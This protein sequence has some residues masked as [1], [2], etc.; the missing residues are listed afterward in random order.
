MSR[1]YQI[2]TAQVEAARK[3]EEAQRARMADKAARYAVGADEFCNGWKETREVTRET[4]ETSKTKIIYVDLRVYYEPT[5]HDIRFDGIVE[6]TTPAPKPSWRT[7]TKQW[8]SGP[9]PHEGKWPLARPSENKEYLLASGKVWPYRA[10][11]WYTPSGAHECGNQDKL[12]WFGYA[13]DADGWIKWDGGKCPVAPDQK[14]QVIWD[15]GIESWEWS[16]K[17]TNAW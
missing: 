10:G 17:E 3:A 1:R 6:V 8:N 16:A 2:L 11:V 13:P 12:L 5:P 15:T 4:W 9:P 7:A 14:V